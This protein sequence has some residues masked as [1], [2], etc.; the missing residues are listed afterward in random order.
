MA[1]KKIK[2][3]RGKNSNS[4]ILTIKTNKTIKKRKNLVKNKAKTLA[5]LIVK[6]ETRKTIIFT[7]V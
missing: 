2:K 5:K 7:S 1:I 4:D 3:S 6:P